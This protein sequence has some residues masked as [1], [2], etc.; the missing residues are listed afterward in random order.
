MLAFL[1]G[2]D[3]RGVPNYNGRP[4]RQCDTSAN[5]CFTTYMNSGDRLKMELRIDMT[6]LREKVVSDGPAFA[7]DPKLAEWRTMDKELEKGSE[8]HVR[9]VQWLMKYAL[10]I[11][12]DRSGVPRHLPRHEHSYVWSFCRDSWVDRG[13]VRH[14]WECHECYEDAWHCGDCGVCKV[15]REYACDT[16]GGWSEL[17]A[18]HGNE[19]GVAVNARDGGKQPA[20]AAARKR[21]RRL[22]LPNEVTEVRLQ[23]GLEA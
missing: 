13:K 19:G 15:G 17:G 5:A 1:F 12:R 9:A 4:H 3:E 22:T 20:T 6:G 2:E 14:C 16:C 11:E 10:G 7:V 21:R 8:A 18:Q 23:L